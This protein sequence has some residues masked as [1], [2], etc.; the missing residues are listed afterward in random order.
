MF[1]KIKGTN[2][3]FIILILNKLNLFMHLHRYASFNY[4]RNNRVYVFKI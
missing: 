1:L 3:M 2:I 4:T